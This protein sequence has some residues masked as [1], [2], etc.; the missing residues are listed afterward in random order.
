M[1][2]DLQRAHDALEHCA[3]SLTPE[4]LAARPPGKW[5]IAEILEHLALAYSATALGAE[6]AA[7][8]GVTVRR[9]DLRSRFRTFVVV[10]CGYFPTGVEAPKMVVPVGIDPG[11][12]LATALGNLERMDAALERAA[13]AFGAGTTLMDHPII[14]PLS[15]R[16]WRRFHRI[17]TRHH[18]RQILR[19][20]GR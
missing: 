6:R 10:E 7:G 8:R 17:H 13:E 2:R 18:A 5:T 14:G 3:G 1:N 9:A 19:R 4:Q 15:T 20:T 16:Q 12:A 11:T